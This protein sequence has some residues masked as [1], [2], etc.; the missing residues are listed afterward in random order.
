MEKNQHIHGT[1]KTAKSGYFFP[2]QLFTLHSLVQLLLPTFRLNG[3]SHPISI[4]YKTV[5]GL[6]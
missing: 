5:H 1:P 4:E 6:N 3:V 2:S